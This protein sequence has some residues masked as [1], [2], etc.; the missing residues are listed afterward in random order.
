MERG[1]KE[2]EGWLVEIWNGEMEI[3]EVISGMGVSE[4]SDSEFRIPTP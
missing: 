4:K 2:F 1:P 3:G